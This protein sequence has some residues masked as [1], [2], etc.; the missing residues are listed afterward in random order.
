MNKFYKLILILIFTF[1]FNINAS[2][3]DKFSE[4]EIKIIDDLRAVY[5]KA[6][7]DDFYINDLEKY[8][9]KYISNNPKFKLY[10][11]AYLGGIEAVKSKHAFWPMKKLNH[12]KEAMKYLSQAID[13]AP[14]N[15]EIRFL[16][17]SILH[18]VPSFLGYGKEREEDANEIFK[19][20]MKKDFS[21]VNKEIQIGI[22]EFM[23]SSERID[24]ASI[25]ILQKEL[26]L[27]R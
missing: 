8:I 20:L 5:Y 17:F 13:L 15:L 2:S 19:L 22:F 3:T 16:R 27:L 10:E 21:L 12:L 24:N 4:S 26:S 11:I 25:K 7:E 18:Y 14:D 1:K 23:I 6:V 9:Y